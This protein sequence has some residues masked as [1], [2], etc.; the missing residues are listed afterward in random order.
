M[1]DKKGTIS[2]SL[3]ATLTPRL[4]DIPGPFL[5]KVI[6]VLQNN[7]RSTTSDNCESIYT[8]MLR[9]EFPRKSRKRERRLGAPF[10]VQVFPLFSYISDD[11]HEVW[12]FF[13][14][15]STFSAYS[16]M[17]LHFFIE[18]FQFLFYLFSLKSG[19]STLTKLQT[20]T[21]FNSFNLWRYYFSH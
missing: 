3:R 13:A 21:A 10:T 12:I 7:F 2:I 11:F 16:M 6:L 4:S 20:K 19:D 18:V 15:S 9:Q 8:N 17:N 14:K 5:R 1:Q